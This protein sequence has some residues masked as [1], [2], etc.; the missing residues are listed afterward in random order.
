MLLADVGSHT[1]E[2]GQSGTREPRSERGT[3]GRQLPARGVAR[4][5][6]RSQLGD[7]RRRRRS[8]VEQIPLQNLRPEHI[9]TL[10]IGAEV[11]FAGACA[12][13]S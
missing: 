5:Q 9:H 8:E 6:L 2:E 10:D 4:Y 3:E 13:D 12:R 1:P 11:P 7:L